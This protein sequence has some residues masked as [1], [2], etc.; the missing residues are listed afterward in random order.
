LKKGLQ[1]AKTV[2]ML[3]KLNSAIVKL[4]GFALSQEQATNIEIIY[5]TC[6]ELGIKRKRHIAYIFATIFHEGARK[7]TINGKTIFRR[8]VSVEEIGKGKGKPY[9]GKIKYSRKYYT[10]PNKIYFGRGF[11]QITWYEVYE[12]FGKLLK[13]D[14]LSNPELALNP[15]IGAKIAVLGMRDGLFT[16]V[17]LERY[18]N[19]S[20]TD[21]INA[22]KIINGTDKADLIASYY[23][24]IFNQII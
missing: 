6:L 23:K 7:E 15:T 3:E 21:A 19:D 18:F 14:L 4:Q 10:I 24:V 16:G 1:N 17:N 13:M 5:N 20:R 12:K 8:V 9:G 11:V 2:E 22:R